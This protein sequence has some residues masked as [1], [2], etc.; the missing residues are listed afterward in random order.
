MS[1]AKHLKSVEFIVVWVVVTLLVNGG[2][3]ANAARIKLDKLVK[4][5]DEESCPQADYS[6]VRL[7]QSTTPVGGS[8]AGN[9]SKVN[10]DQTVDTCLH[11]CCLLKRCDAM[12]YHDKSCFHISC[13][14]DA[15]CKPHIERSAT[16]RNSFLAQVRSVSFR[17]TT[18]RLTD[19]DNS[20]DTASPLS[21]VHANEQPYYDIS[22]ILQPNIFER[23]SGTEPKI[24]SLP[25]PCRVGMDPVECGDHE[26]CVST[27]RRGKGTC[28]CMEGFER[29]GGDNCIQVFVPSSTSE[30]MAESPGEDTT[31]AMSKVKDAMKPSPAVTVMSEPVTLT[32]VP[33]TPISSTATVISTD[34]PPPQLTIVVQSNLTITLPQNSTSIV[35]T[36][37]PVQ[38]NDT[39]KY[40]W[41]FVSK[42]EGEELGV[43]TGSNSPVLQLA[44]LRPG[45]YVFKVSVTSGHA[46]GEKLVNVTVLPAKHTNRSPVAIIKP[47]E[48]TVQLPNK[49]TVLDGSSSTDDTE[50]IDYKWEPMTLPIG[51]QSP[52]GLELNN[53]KTLQ[54]KNLIPGF[55]QFKLT[56]IDADHAENSTVANVTV[57]KEKDYPPTA[58]AGADV[59]LKLPKNE[60]TLNGNQSTDDK[61]IIGWQW[62]RAPDDE[63]SLAVDMDGTVTPYLH[64]SKLEL[65]MYKFLLKVTDTANQTSTAEVHVFVQPQQFKGPEAV[66][67]PPIELNLPIEVPIYLDGA[68]STDDSPEGLVKYNWLQV[69]GPKN[70][71]I[72]NCSWPKTEVMGLIPGKYI[73][74]LTVTNG[75]GSNSSANATITVTQSKNTPPRANAGGD[76]VITLPQSVVILNGSRSW[77]DFAILNWTWTRT[78]K[79]LAAGRILKGTDKGPVLELTDLIP[80]VYGFTLTVMDKQGESSSNEVTLTVKPPI[81]LLN[82]VEATLDTD[83][84]SFSFEQ[85]STTLKRLELLLNDGKGTPLK[86]NKVSLESI[87]ITKR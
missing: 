20:V 39:Y 37:Q 46:H 51:F 27:Q 50:V 49:D 73:F 38:A 86:V 81:D 43:M 57:L 77:D 52:F 55:Y 34:L 28:V 64:L 5:V 83:I 53:T 4:E 32:P 59:I 14:S 19:G 61:N 87:P 72:A 15:L 12:F 78:S 67:Q 29:D 3:S 63:K 23:R 45:R 25:R 8:L 31:Q 35:A 47:L 2:W 11:A 9:Y 69:E 41:S 1:R 66:V 54:L 74:Q 7:Y 82:R 44:N 76:Q 68:K 70:A 48:Q 33:V 71:N 13:F 85:E 79:S 36:V 16:F 18:S 24:P 30:P 65:G 80:G 22:S 56:V 62:T 21:V 26:H 10:G 58:N 17:T 60:V 84:E 40:E 6:P 42:P 75:R